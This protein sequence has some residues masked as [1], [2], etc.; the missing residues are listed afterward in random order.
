MPVTDEQIATL[1]AQ[2]AGR[3]DEHRRLLDQLDRA[4]AST[5]YSALVAAGVFEAADRRFMQ[6]GTPA[7]DSDVIDFVATVRASSQA[8]TE[9]L[10]PQIAER[11]IL[12]ALGKGEIDDID[13]NTVIGHQMFL[14]A[15]LVA[16][17]HF[18]AEELSTFLTQAR[19]TADHWLAQ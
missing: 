2:L 3:T 15:A 19:E 6:G 18:N 16:D 5:G 8:A 10:D 1:E 4:E 17:E 11:I 13:D 14:L 9:A 12:A 7:P